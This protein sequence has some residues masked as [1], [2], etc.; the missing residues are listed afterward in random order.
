MFSF[1]QFN[2]INRT[3][4]MSVYKKFYPSG[5]F[6]DIEKGTS[7]EDRNEGKK[8][9][10]EWYSRIDSRSDRGLM[11]R[12]RDW[13]HVMRTQWYKKLL[14]KDIVKFKYMPCQRRNGTFEGK[15]RLCK[16][17]RSQNVLARTLIYTLTSGA[18]KSLRNCTCF[19]V[20]F[21]RICIAKLLLLL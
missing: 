12:D 9:P 21:K 1:P 6:R 10:C 18:A 14:E 8:M 20:C 16:I 11:G 19:P 7:S 13:F 3:P 4:D 2:F 5:T 17:C 15:F